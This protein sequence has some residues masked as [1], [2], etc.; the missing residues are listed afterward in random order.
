MIRSLDVYV[1]ANG[2]YSMTDIFHTLIHLHTRR[3]TV[4]K[5]QMIS[6]PFIKLNKNLMI[7][8][9]TYSFYLK[10]YLDFYNNLLT[11]EGY[12]VYFYKQENK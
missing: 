7:T 6:K 10:Y 11:K 4:E 5:L 8:V 1:E 12:F 3:E 9:L 2:V